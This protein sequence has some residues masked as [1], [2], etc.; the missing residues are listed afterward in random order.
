MK[1]LVMR[2]NLITRVI[3]LVLAS[4]CTTGP[5]TPRRG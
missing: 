3:V 4:G 1:E 5:V 2:S